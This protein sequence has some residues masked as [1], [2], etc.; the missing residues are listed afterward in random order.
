MT[1]IALGN[2]V[3][4]NRIK[5]KVT[6]IDTV[7]KKIYSRTFQDKKQIPGLPRTF[8]ESCHPVISRWHL[9]HFQKQNWS[10]SRKN[11]KNFPKI[12]HKNG[13]NIVIQCNLKIVDD[14]DVT[15]NLFNNIYRPF[16]KSN[17]KIN[18]IH[19][20]SKHPPSVIKYLLLLSHGYQAFPQVGK[21]LMS[22]KLFIKK[23]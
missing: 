4:F 18:Y 13:L 16:S 22:L 19:K 14:L 9:G 8:Q 15:L 12:F 2:I 20:E 23:H 21:F 6:I 10:T 5:S 7:N 1:K 11:Q 3:H 17:S